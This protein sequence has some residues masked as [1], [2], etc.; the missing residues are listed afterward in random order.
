MLS[1]R[2]GRYIPRKYIYGGFYIIFVVGLLFYYVSLTKQP[3][4]FSAVHSL[5]ANPGSLY[6]KLFGLVRILFLV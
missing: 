3:R 6:G 1:F 5:P 2:F 4:Q